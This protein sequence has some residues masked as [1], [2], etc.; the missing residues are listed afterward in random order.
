VFWGYPQHHWLGGHG[1]VRWL[2]GLPRPL[3][4]W[5]ALAAARLGRARGQERWERLGYLR[6]GV[7][8]EGVYLALR[9]FFAP[10][11]IARLLDGEQ[12]E[13]ERRIRSLVCDQPAEAGAA[14]LA[15]SFNRLEFGRYLHDQLLRDTDVF[16]MAHSIEVRVPY[17]DHEVVEAMALVPARRR[18][19]TGLNKPVLCRAVGDPLVLEL[20]RVRK[21]GFTLPLDRWMREHA[22]LLEGIAGTSGRLDPDAVRGLWRE[23]RADRL[24]WSRAWAL[25]VL[26]NGYAGRLG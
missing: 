13:L 4:A 6:S 14:D 12:A 25:V 20:G 2:L 3:G 8:P 23:F 21:R 17:L 22:G 15:V 5:S 7:S 19:A 11:Q 10:A 24:H 18:L 1:P 26:G 9:G 16:A